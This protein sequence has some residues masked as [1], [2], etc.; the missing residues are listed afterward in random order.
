MKLKCLGIM[1]FIAS[2]AFAQKLVLRAEVVDENDNA[3]EGVEAVVTVAGDDAFEMKGTTDKKG[4]LTIVGMKSGF[5]TVALSKE[6]YASR[7]YEYQQDQARQLEHIKMFSNEATLA[8]D[9]MRPRLTGKVID[10]QGKGIP[11]VE[12]T[13]SV[14]GLPAFEHVLTT[15]EDGR[16]ATRGLADTTVKIY[17]RKAEYR[18]WIYNVTMGKK[19]ADISDF[20]IP[21]LDEAY[22]EMGIER[23]KEVEM[24][25]KDKAIEL[26]NKAVDP[27][28][29]E[30]YKEAEEIVLQALALVPD[31]DAALKLAI[32][33][34]QAQEDWDDVL[35]YSKAYLKVVPNDPKITQI[36]LDAA[37][38]TNKK[39][40][41]KKYE[42][43][44][45]KTGQ[46]TPD[47]LFN[48]AVDWLN[49]GNDE[50]ARPL[51]DEVLK[52]DKNYA[53]AYLEIGKIKVREFEFE[54]A[55]VQLKTYL[56]LAPK[57]DPY[58][59]E[60]EDLIITLAE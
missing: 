24:T 15:D 55:I 14:E 43:I 41:V 60:A 22:K 36:A 48:K 35:K 3:I 5:V 11:G 34:N 39:D 7:T 49:Q 47:S 40:E 51:L 13:F 12:L 59:K 37:N 20:K 52:L 2:A 27:Y 56:K 53:R 9:A 58:R 42:D 17:A 21:T 50:K 16:F 18:D 45:I 30:N 28:Q 8:D 26:Y 1:L 6:G 33:A 44:L 57:N 29:A 31:M 19:A 38:L 10:S 46:I 25:D 23:P 32:F 4:Y 54:D